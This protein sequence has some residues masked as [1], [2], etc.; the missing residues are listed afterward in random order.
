[1]SEK[2]LTYYDIGLDEQLSITQDV[3]D[4][5]QRNQVRLA[6]QREIIISIARLNINRDIEILN[7]IEEILRNKNV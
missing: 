2:N 6:K 1:M 5:F 7:K 4:E 3:I